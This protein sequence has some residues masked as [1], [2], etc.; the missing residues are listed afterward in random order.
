MGK[1][2]LKRNS[3]LNYGPFQTIKSLPNV[4]MKISIL[5]S[6]LKQIQFKVK[7]TKESYLMCGR[8]L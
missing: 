4:L 7:Q 3:R 2:Y 5:F 8:D 6:F 1:I